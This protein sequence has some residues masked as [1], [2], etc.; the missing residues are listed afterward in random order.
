M[1]IEKSHWTDVGLL[2]GM[3]AL[4]LLALR[5]EWELALSA[6]FHDPAAGW[7]FNERRWVQLV[8]KWATLPALLLA[9]AGLLTGLGAWFWA[10]LRPYRTIGWFLGLSMILGP[11]LLINSAF[12]EHFHRPRPR[13]LVEFGGE[14]QFHQLGELGSGGKGKS[15]PSGHASMGYFLAAPYLFLRQRRRH[16]A[17]GFVL[18]GALAGLGIGMVRVMQ[19]AHFLGDVIAS[20]LMVWIACQATWELLN[21]GPDSPL[22]HRPANP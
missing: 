2:L 21:R 16:L 5:P 8:D 15:F 22:R 20:G 18:L 12:K 9:I 11:G 19:G 14:A 6:R 1:K 17:T 13:Q 3:A 4:L 7:F 10:A